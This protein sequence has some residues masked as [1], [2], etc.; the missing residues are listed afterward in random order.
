MSL[1]VLENINFFIL[2]IEFTLF[3]CFYNSC[4]K[5]NRTLLWDLYTLQAIY[6]LP[7]GGAE[8][9]EKASPE[10]MYGGS[11]STSQQKRY[12]V[13]WNPVMRGVVSTCSFD[14]KVQVHSVLGAATVSLT[15][16]VRVFFAIVT[17]SNKRKNNLS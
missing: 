11:L 5:D 1:L 6:E 17:L 12:D 10:S 2:V 16:L 9:V 15:F 14:R 4:G 8:A 3:R 7:A 13:Q